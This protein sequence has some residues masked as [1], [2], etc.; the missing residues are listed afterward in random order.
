[1]T[2]TDSATENFSFNALDPNFVQDPLPFMMHGLADYPIV[3]HGPG[4]EHAYS[5]FRYDDV[6][7]TLLDWQTFSSEPDPALDPINLGRA[8]ENFI[9]MDPPR[10]TRLRALANRG[11]TRQIIE[12]FIPRAEQIVQ[13][14]LQYLVDND[15]IDL[16]DDFSAQITVG[17]I[18]GILGL[19][20]ED[21]PIIREWTN[22][23]QRNTMCS[24]WLKVWDDER[25]NATARVTNEM[26]D[27]FHDYLLQRKK[28]PKEGDVISVLMT[29]DLKG[30]RFSDE[31]IESTAM[32]L[33]LA[34]NETTT[35]LIT[36]FVRC[37]VWFPEQFELLKK[38]PDL[39]DSAIEE[40]LRLE[41]S[42]RMD[43]RLVTK[44]ITVHGVDIEAGATIVTWILAANRDPRVFERPNEFEIE[45]ESNRHL[46]FAAGPHTCIGSRL[47][48]MESR[49]AAS[50]FVKQV[51][52]VEL[53][54]E[55]V[56]SDNGN[57]NNVL[58]QLARVN[59]V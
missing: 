41:P 44:P 56:M 10:H 5:V 25:A 53:L 33:L 11:F 20:V 36:N 4:L 8:T 51:K 18:T 9:L 43:A 35:N 30:D 46:A 27:Y 47:A 32:L 14:R 19:P 54:G 37:M 29:R 40:T 7:K 57:L 42:L 45:R 31:E 21:W 15:E 3:D 1:M 22:V 39:I 38:R 2:G 52:S 17:M 26:A 28:H 59:A 24:S 23:I 16:V 55:P 49:I 6:K 58:H 50:A 12:K 13:E 48:R 34:G